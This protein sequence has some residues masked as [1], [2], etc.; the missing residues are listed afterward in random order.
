LA[1]WAERAAENEK[2][3]MG[4]EERRPAGLEKKKGREREED[5]VFLKLLFKLLKFKLFFKL[6]ANFTQTIKPCIQITMHKHLLL[7]NY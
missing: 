5:L 7:L 1:R 4:G 2:E 3:K 6:F